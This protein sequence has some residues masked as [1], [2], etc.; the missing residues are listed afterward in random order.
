MG[1]HLSNLPGKSQSQQYHGYTS[2]QRLT[3]S[4]EESNQLWI[5][6]CLCNLLRSERCAVRKKKSVGRRQ[7]DFKWVCL[8]IWNANILQACHLSCFAFKRPCWSM[9]GHPLLG[10]MYGYVLCW[11]KNLNYH[12]M[13][14]WFEYI[15]LQYICVLCV[16]ILYII[17]IYIII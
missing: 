7:T 9:L 4:S 1:L 10:D 6:C 2:S 16:S 11:D 15:H 13:A 5:G 3:F 8:K 17:Y 14:T 12:H